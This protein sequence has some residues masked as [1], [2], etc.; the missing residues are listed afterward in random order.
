MEKVKRK[1]W[2]FRTS[3]AYWSREDLSLGA[4]AIG[5]ILLCYADEDGMAF[6]TTPKIAKDA[7]ISS[8]TTDKHLREL[9]DAGAISWDIWKDSHGHKRRRFD[10]KRIFIEPW[11]GLGGKKKDGRRTMM[12]TQMQDGSMG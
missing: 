7:R 6:P 8:D 4:K 2:T 10:L 9:R 1:S 12:S 3:K 5:A 11:D